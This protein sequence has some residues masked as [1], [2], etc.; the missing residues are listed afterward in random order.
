[1]SYSVDFTWLLLV[2]LPLRLTHPFLSEVFL[3]L[4]TEEE[5]VEVP[6][7]SSV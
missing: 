4:F 5:D 3:L 2:M 7:Q 1:M 6:F